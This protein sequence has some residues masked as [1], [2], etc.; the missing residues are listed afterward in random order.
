ME[1]TNFSICG[2]KMFENFKKEKPTEEPMKSSEA[3]ETLAKR[4]YNQFLELETRVCSLEIKI[5]ELM[6][7][8]TEKNFKKQN[9][10]SPFGRRIR[11]RF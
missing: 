7:L 9:K 4:L 6:A 3:E 8:L 11:E 1:K 10:L 2:K 5:V